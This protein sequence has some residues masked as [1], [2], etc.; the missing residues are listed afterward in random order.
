MYDADWDDEQIY[1][2]ESKLSGLGGAE[3]AVNPANDT[4]AGE[5][6]VER[7][8][9]TIDSWVLRDHVRLSWSSNP[10]SSALRPDEHVG[11]STP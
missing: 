6:D 8:D 4:Q 9:R 2:E 7:P 1:Y 3:H 5:G 11:L 10:S